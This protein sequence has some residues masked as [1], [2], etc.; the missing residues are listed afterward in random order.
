MR[1][2][3]QSI[4]FLSTILFGAEAFAQHTISGKVIASSGAPVPNANV[5]LLNTIDG[6]TSDSNGVFSFTTE[7]TGSQTLV[8]EEMSY[9]NA[10]MPITINGDVAGI[11]L[12]MKLSSVR[13]KNVTVTA[14]SFEASGSEAT[15]LKPLDIVTTA[16]SQA[17]VVKAI[18][19]SC[20]T[21]P[22]WR[23]LLHSL[24]GRSAQQAPAT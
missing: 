5:Y 1:Q 18:Q 22:A 6:G 2:I 13:L 15:I 7:E 10:G 3:L 12:R 11:E 14:G 24:K 21:D 17:D 20:T 16:G 9:Q 8:A 4:F 19:T 23:V